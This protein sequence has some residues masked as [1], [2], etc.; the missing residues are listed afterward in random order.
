[1]RTFPRTLGGRVFW[2]DRLVRRAHRLQEHVRLGHHRVLTPEN[3]RLHSSFSF[4]DALAALGQAAPRSRSAPR[5]VVFLLHGYGGRTTRMA[6]LRDALQAAGLAAEVVQHPSLLRNVDEVAANIAKLVTESVSNSTTVS[7]VGFSMGGLVSVRAANLLVAQRG[8]PRVARVVTIGTPF[9]GSP[10]ADLA[11]FL[12][13]LGGPT[14][15]N[16]RQ[17]GVAELTREDVP[18]GVIAGRGHRNGWTALGVLGTGD[19]VVELGSAAP[20]GATDQL[21]V[22]GVKHT[23][24][25]AN[26]E[27]IAGVVRFLRRGRF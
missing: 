6:P 27:V 17:R 22:H 20:E 15:A 11:S 14:V 21:V 25:P 4:D 10:L 19:G 16:L 1:M 3:R 18:L 7:F 5:Q 2:R 13:V 8:A 12:T 23:R 24:L 9:Q 26:G